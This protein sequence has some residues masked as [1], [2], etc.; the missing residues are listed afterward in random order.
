M[1]AWLGRSVD[2][3]RL[4]PENL[5]Q[6]IYD[7]THVVVNGGPWCG[8]PARIRLVFSIP[9]AKLRRAAAALREFAADLGVA[10]QDTV[11]IGDGANDLAMMATAGLGIAFNA[12][13]VVQAQADVALNEP[14][15]DAALPYL[16]L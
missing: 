14:R 13:P 2:G 1:S 7:H 4:T 3:V 6:V 8:D 9:E 12:K 11:A 10:L 16:G 15:L 5:P